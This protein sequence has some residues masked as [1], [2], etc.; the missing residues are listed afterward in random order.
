VPS[1]PASSNGTWHTNQAAALSKD[2]TQNV[3]CL[4][5]HV[6]WRAYP[7]RKGNISLDN[8]EKEV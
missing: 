6:G 5:R 4:S 8:N 3:H 1:V 2:K 7:K